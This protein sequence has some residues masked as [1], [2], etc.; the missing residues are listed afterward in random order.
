MEERH[1]RL[2]CNIQRLVLPFAPHASK[3]D[4]STMQ[5]HPIKLLLVGFDGRVSL[6]VR[7]IRVWRV[8]LSTVCACPCFA[9]HGDISLLSKLDLLIRSTKGVC[10]RRRRTVGGSSH[11]ASAS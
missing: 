7:I 10:P 6:T 5:S 4:C 2:L 9:V 11:N 8:P 3:A 1:H